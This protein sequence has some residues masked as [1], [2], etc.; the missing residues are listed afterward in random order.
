MLSSMFDL[1]L[2]TLYGAA[3]TTH[4]LVCLLSVH[5]TATHDCM[6][7]LK[8][9]KEYQVLNQTSC[10]TWSSKKKT[11]QTRNKRALIDCH[12]LCSK[13][14]RRLKPRKRVCVTKGEANQA[15]WEKFV[16][17]V[18]TRGKKVTRVVRGSICFRFL[19]DPEFRKRTRRHIDKSQVKYVTIQVQWLGFCPSIRV[20]QT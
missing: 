18:V 19:G 3:I 2:E 11:H 4:F 16:P 15:Q 8:S 13:R 10:H 17:K 12:I 14:L 9:D 7:N 5:C 1:S 6:F 20:A